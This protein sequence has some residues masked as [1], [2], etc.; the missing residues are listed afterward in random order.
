M[1]RYTIDRFEDK[2]WAVLEDDDQV[3]V[4][5]PRSWLPADAREGDVVDA[6]DHDDIPGMKTVRFQVD[7]AA[8]DV[9]LDEAR[10]LRDRLPKGP[11]G[12]ISL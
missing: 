6:S 7:T 5:I 4:T 3:R 11:K 9:R 12:D 10:Q 1:K 2:K 8:R